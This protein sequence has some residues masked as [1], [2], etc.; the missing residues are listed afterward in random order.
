MLKLFFGGEVVTIEGSECFP[1]EEGH[2]DFAFFVFKREVSLF[3]FD[4]RRVFVSLDDVVFFFV[5]TNDTFEEVI[6]VLEGF[7]GTRS[8]FPLSD[9]FEAN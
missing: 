4:E 3:L 1:K 7:I 8:V 5:S 6:L 9:K 2:F